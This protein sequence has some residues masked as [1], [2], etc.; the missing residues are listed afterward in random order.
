MD[1]EPTCCQDF[2]RHHEVSAE[3]GELELRCLFGEMTQKG[4]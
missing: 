3:S 1:P 2:Q 4:P